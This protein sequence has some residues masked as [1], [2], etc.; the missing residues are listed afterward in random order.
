M[1]FFEGASEMGH[2]YEYDEVDVD[3]LPFKIE[4]DVLGLDNSAI[5]CTIYDDETDEE[6]VVGFGNDEYD[7][8]RN[9]EDKL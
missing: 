5:R 8:R 9:A 6:L 4:R 2:R 1:I 7:A 3:I